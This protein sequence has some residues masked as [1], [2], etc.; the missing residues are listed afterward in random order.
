M[1]TPHKNNKSQV[2]TM[3]IGRL[4]PYNLKVNDNYFQQISVSG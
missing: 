2:N 3:N 1:N 4:T